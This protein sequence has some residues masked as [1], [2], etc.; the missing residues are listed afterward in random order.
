MARIAKR[1]TRIRI[2]DTAGLPDGYDAANLEGDGCDDPDAWLAARLR[3][4][5]QREDDHE[6]PRVPWV[7]VRLSD[8]AGRAVPERR[9]IVPDWI[10]REQ[11]TGL[12]GVGGI[13]KTDWLIQMLMSSAAG[14][15]VPRSSPTRRSVDQFCPPTPQGRR[16]APF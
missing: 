13:N 9:W 6:L 16:A 10:P 4:P 7:D 15:P 14:L 5:E 3:E 11:V 8:W 2:V 1:L 12:Y